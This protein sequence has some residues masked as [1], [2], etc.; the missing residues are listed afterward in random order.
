MVY[1]TEEVGHEGVSHV[2]QVVVVEEGLVDAWEAF[3]ERVVRVITQFCERGLR[4][5]RVME[6]KC[7]L[8]DDL[9]LV[10]LLCQAIVIKVWK[11][12]SQLEDLGKPGYNPLIINNLNHFM[13]QQSIGYGQ[14]PEFMCLLCELPHSLPVS[15]LEEGEEV[16]HDVEEGKNLFDL[17]GLGL[18]FF[19]EAFLEGLQLADHVVDEAVVFLVAVVAEGAHQQPVR[20]QRLVRLQVRIE[21]GQVQLAL[22]EVMHDVTHLLQLPQTV[23]LVFQR[24]CHCYVLRQT[25]YLA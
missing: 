14:H 12:F 18:Q 6:H 2:V 4:V 16:N 11:I 23:H 19:V 1:V 7:T 3:Q 5:V 17:F 10:T 21:E 24:Q 13:R 15:E 20:V 25:L 8:V 9:V 22:R